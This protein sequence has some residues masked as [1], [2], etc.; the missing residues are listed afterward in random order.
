MVNFGNVTNTGLNDAG[1]NYADSTITISFIAT[2]ITNTKYT[3][4]SVY[5]TVGAEYNSQNYIWVSQAQYSYSM[6]P[7]SIV[8]FCERC[9]NKNKKYKSLYYES[10]KFG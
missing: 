3:N 7:V 9:N 4:T 8:E 10:F 6:T 1:T 5:V 2:L